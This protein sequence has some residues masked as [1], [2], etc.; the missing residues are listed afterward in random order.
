LRRATVRRS[1]SSTNPPPDE[2]VRVQYVI[3][4]VILLV[5][6]VTF[7]AAYYASRTWHWANVTLVVLL[8]FTGVFYMVLAADV[9]RVRAVYG[10]QIENSTEQLT[11]FL[12]RNKALR[13]GTDDAQLSNRIAGDEVNVS[14]DEGLVGTSTLEHRLEMRT[15]ARGRVWRGAG[16]L[17]ADPDTGI[18][19]VE[20]LSPA[21][22]G[23]DDNTIILVFEQ[24]PAAEGRQYL[25]EFRVVEAIEGGV[26]IE[27]TIALDERQQERFDASSGPW[28]LYE[29]M[30]V[31]EHAL[32]DPLSDE[33]L[34]EILPAETVEE[35]VRH[36]GE[37]A[38]D[39][40]EWHV[41]AFD[42]SDRQ[43]GPEAAAAADNVRYR[44][45]RT[46]RDYGFLFQNLAQQRVVM[47]ADLAAMEKDIER[48]T[49]ALEGADQL[50][51]FREDEKE[52]LAVDL[53]GM[54]K[55]RQAIERHLAQVER[56]VHVAKNLF[57]RT[58]RENAQRARQL[59]QRQQ[60]AR[61]VADQQASA[62]PRGRL[63][64]A[65]R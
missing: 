39:D 25:G 37:R 5:A 51:T 56:Q 6:I 40:D 62:R 17:D 19:A 26:H 34:Q 29:T 65:V 8:F 49:Q 10:R 47:L 36:G 60:A 24:G 64:E 12:A 4:G 7:V 32:F 50:R 3:W 30:P 45:N 20:V 14:D 16:P 41:A 27:P 28:A 35:Y 42:E 33:T 9:I 53:A 1:S 48:L 63:L 57:E 13:E 11:D 54:I 52:K 59:A 31:D 15:R 18:V 23:I 58:I 44:Y 43:L 22:H 46:L 21:P 38:N 2:G 55:D 61:P